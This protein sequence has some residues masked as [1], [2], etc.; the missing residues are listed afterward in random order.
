MRKTLLSSAMGS[1]PKLGCAAHA[2]RQGPHLR[3]GW[4]R[5]ERRQLV[6][7]RSPRSPRRPRARRG[8]GGR[9]R[10]GGGGVVVLPGAARLR[11]LQASRRA[12]KKRPRGGRHGEGA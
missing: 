8:G 1:F 4:R 3:S 6:P 11:A 7:P 10:G 5:R 12:P 2:L 9:G